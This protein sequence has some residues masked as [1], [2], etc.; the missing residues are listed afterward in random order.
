MTTFLGIDAG[1]TGVKA[2]LFDEKG[3]ELARAFRDTGTTIPAPGFVE[4]DIHRLRNDLEGLIIEVLDKSGKSGKDI[5]GIGTS[6][7]GNGLYLLDK[8][9]EPVI[10]IQSLDSRAAQLAHVWHQDGTAQ[11]AEAICFQ[12]PWASQTPTLL[13]WISRQQPEILSN[14]AH[15]LMCKDVVTHALT[16]QIVSDVSDMGGA[17]LLALP[18]NVYSGELLEHYGLA[19]YSHVLPQLLWP[20]D[21]AGSVTES[22]AKRTGLLS[23]T[24]VIA[25]FFD[26]IASAIGAGVTQIG[27]ASVI[28]GTWSINQAIV[29]NPVP[30]IFMSCGILPGR[31]MAMENSA[32]S[33]TNL[34]WVSQHVMGGGKEAFTD[35]DRLAMETPARADAPLYHPYLYGGT[36]DPTA[37]AGLFGV[38]GWHSSG[39]VM[40][41]IFEGVAFAHLEHLKRLKAKNVPTDHIVLSGGGSRSPVWPQM[42][43][44]ML[45][46]TVAVSTQPEAGALGAAM[47]ASVGIGMYDT[48]D[49]ASSAM[50]KPPKFVRP[51]LGRLSFYQKRFQ[52][53]SALAASLSPHWQALKELA[54][55]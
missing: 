21:I 4:R 54:G 31:F 29:P 6:G 12:K 8:A 1:N 51:D 7:H 14:T 46:Q 55:E 26:V 40:R 5:A 42:L 28:L 44:D 53:W 33:A 37:R 49:H 41:S 48:L 9:H 15:V 3:G 38:A 13:A 27:Q 2:V 50:A 19:R 17:G 18:A 11:A 25:G 20:T 34:E 16:G 43:A 39:D 47:A 32:T 52:L 24:P 36:Q 22:V 10:A 30:D 23:G 35:A 45:G